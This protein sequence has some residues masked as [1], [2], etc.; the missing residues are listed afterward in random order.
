[1]VNELKKLEVNQKLLKNELG[2]DYDSWL[3]IH[4]K[5]LIHHVKV[6]PMKNGN[7]QKML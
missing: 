6:V 4:M 3:N 7:Q 2:V 1:M 5:N